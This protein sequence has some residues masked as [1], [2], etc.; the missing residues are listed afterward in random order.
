MTDKIWLKATGEIEDRYI[1]NY[2]LAKEKAKKKAKSIKFKTWGAIAACLAV[3]MLTSYGV[4]YIPKNYE[5]GT[6]DTGNDSAI[7]PLDIWVYYVGPF[8][9]MLRERVRIT[10][11]RPGDGGGVKG[12]F[13][14]WKDY[15]NIGDDVELLERRIEGQT[16]IVNELGDRVLIIVPGEVLDCYVTVSNDILNYPNHEKLMEAFE[17]TLVKTYE[18]DWNYNFHIAIEEP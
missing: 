12:C 13:M 15:N 2:L 1:E 5:L 7:Q 3:V 9:M 17:K 6:H 14:V 18:V 8:D 11:P 10:P 4:S 16:F